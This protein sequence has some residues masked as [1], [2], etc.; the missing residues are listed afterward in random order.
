MPRTDEDI[1]R[2]VMRRCTEDMHAP[3][4]IAAQVVTR[5]RRRDRRGRILTLT[6]TTAALGTAAGVVA[7]VP[8]QA[9]QTPGAHSTQPAITLTAAQRTLYRLSSVAAGAP[10]G[11]GRYAVMREMQDNYKKMSVIDSVTGDVWTYQRGAGVPAELPVARHDSPTQAQFAAMPTDP[12]ALRALLISQY[13]QQQKRADAAMADQLREKNK[14]LRGQHRP[15]IK[16]L[17]LTA[18]DK[19]F[20]QANLLL[21]NPLA[22]PALRSAVF[23]VLAATPGVRVDSHARDQLGRP[24]VKISWFDR[25]TSVTLATFEDPSTTRVLEQTDTSTPAAVNGHSSSSGRDLYLSVTRSR[26]VPANPYR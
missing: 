8:R 3:A 14:I 26:T 11:Q 7:L 4:S 21:W 17:K 2:T 15:V 16:P 18:D 9:A 5:Q 1:L 22:G 19:V 23:R 25:V 24:A 10:Q 13:D 20:E 6:A 12:A